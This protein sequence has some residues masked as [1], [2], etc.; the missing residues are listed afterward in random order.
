V[1]LTIGSSRICQ[2]KHDFGLGFYQWQIALTLVVSSGNEDEFKEVW[3]VDQ[4]QAG[5]LES[6][7]SCFHCRPF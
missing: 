5:T 2:S 3:P 7:V 1:L 4:P 6:T